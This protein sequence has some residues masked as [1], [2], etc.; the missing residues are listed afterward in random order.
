MK[1]LILDKD[2]TLFPYSLWI[3]PIKR[4]LEENL[5][6]SRFGEEKKERI[7]KDFLSV[8]SI[9]DDK[10]G[11]DSLLYDRKKRV[12]GI[13]SLIFLTFK[14]ALNPIKAMRGFL[15]IKKRA[16]YSFSDAFSTYDFTAV[17]KT[18]NALREK[19]ITLAVFT[20]DSPRSI[21]ALEERL[22]F[23]F[24]YSVDSSSRIRKPNKLTVLIFSTL[25]NIKTE[26]IVFV[27][28]T[29]EDLKMARKAGCGMIVG[30]SSS[31]EEEKLIPYADSVIPSFG[32]IL[33]Y[34][35]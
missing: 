14:Y 28:D 25:Y 5:P 4:C 23:H 29:I 22:D 12:K 6:L 21:E 34:F 3:E 1:A 8:L 18:L 24:D 16:V 32:Y 33:S 35:N 17:K 15:K 20:N 13:I 9:K 11:S 26:D 31:I 19:E 7:V 10:I 30:V 2:G 27:S